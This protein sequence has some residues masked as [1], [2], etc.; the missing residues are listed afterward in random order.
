MNNQE[1]T[2][3]QQLAEIQ[4]KL[5]EIGTR[6]RGR[7]QVDELAVA[8]KELARA[9]LIDR[10]EDQHGPVGQGIAVFEAPNGELVIVKKPAAQTYRKF[11]DSKAQSTEAATAFI[12][13]CVV[14]P[15]WEAVEALL[16]EY[17]AILPRIALGCA[18]LAGFR[19]DEKS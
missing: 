8:E 14:H 7:V 9:E 15:K 13:P 11:Q 10:I 6:R 18:K 5:K 2:K 17:P 19:D 3:E 12:R 4:A 16:D 1:K